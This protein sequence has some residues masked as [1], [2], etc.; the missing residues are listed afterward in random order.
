MRGFSFRVHPGFIFMGYLFLQAAGC[1]AGT[2]GPPHAGTN[3]DKEENHVESDIEIHS[4][5]S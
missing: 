3:P 4:N 5:A 2:T 1:P